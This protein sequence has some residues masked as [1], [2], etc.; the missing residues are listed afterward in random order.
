[1]EFK[2]AGGSEGGIIRYFVGLLM[3]IGGLYLLLRSI[4]VMNFW[5]HGMFRFGGYD[6]T[7]GYLLIPF[8]FGV[9]MIFYNSQN[10]LGWIL[11]GGALVALIFGVITSV[12]LTLNG[13]SAFDLLIILTLTVGG[14]GLLLSSLR[15]RDSSF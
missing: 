8:M 2:G 13:M 10:W 7:T 5:G 4:H 6:I 3:F 11:S 14:L 12:Q 9:G 1:M 15:R